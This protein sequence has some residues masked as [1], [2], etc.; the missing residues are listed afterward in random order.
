MS[1]KG[2]FRLELSSRLSIVAMIFCVAAISLVFSGTAVGQDFKRS[3]GSVP[4]PMDWS[5]HHVIYTVGFTHEQASKML[6]DPRFFVATRSHGKALAD[7]M[8]AMKTSSSDAS[9]A[10]PRPAENW[11]GGG[12]NVMPRRTRPTLKKDW[13]ISLGAGGVAQ[14]MFP[15]KYSFDVTAT[16]SCSAD[17]VVFPINAS[18]GNTR[19]HVVGTF[20]AEPATGG[21]TTITVTP[22][23]GTAATLTLTSSASSNSGLYFEVSST[24]AT[25]ATNLA[26]AIN[27][28]LS[29]VALDGV[30]AV[31]SGS[32]VTV[33]TLTPGTRV[34]L[35]DANTLT[36]F[37]W[38][39]VTAGTNG[40]QANIVAMNQLYS[41]TETSGTSLCGLTNPEFIF[42]YASGVGPVA[43]S[44]TLS[45]TGKKVA[46]VENDTNIGAILHILTFGSGSTEYGTSTSC[47][48]NNNGGSTLPTCATSPVIPGSTSGS[49]ATDFMLPLGLVAANASTGVAGAA[50]SFSSPFTNYDDDTTFV[51]DNNGYLYA[52]K[53][54]FIGTPAYAGGNFPVHVSATPTSVTPTA[55]T[56]TTT[57]VTVTATNS[58]GIG[59][60]VT[61][62]GVA[63]NGN[64]CS[65][66]DATAI[67]GTQTVISSSS[68]QFTFDATI[69]RATTGAGCT[70]TNATVTAGSNYLSS[71]VVD[72]AGTGN[73]FVA[74]SSSNLYELTS[75]G[76]TA[77]TAISVGENV[78]GGVRVAPMIDST[79]AVGYVTT[80][81]NANA[82]GETDAANPALVQFKF[83]SNTLTEVG[84]AALDT[85]MNQNC[86]VA[87]YP[88]YDPTPDDRYYALGISSATAASNGEFIAASSGTGGQQIKAFQFVSSALQT[89]PEAKPQIGDGPSPL[90]PLTEFYNSESFTVSAVTATTSVV[91]VTAANAL[92][93]NDLVTISGVTSNS[94]CSAADVAAINGLQTVASAST[95]QF[96]FAATIP[97]ATSGS[98]C[99]ITS[100]TAVG[101][102]D[103]MFMGVVQNTT[104]AYSF[105][106]P[107]G[108]VSGSYAAENT[109]SVTGGTSGIVVDN[110]STSAQASSLYFGTLATSTSQCG[111][112]A[113]YCAVKLTQSLLE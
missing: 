80:A 19:A 110:D 54:T 60:L 109:S 30:A 15:A 79:N 58:L 111:T 46:Y 100:A 1:A 97:T 98:G 52:I 85:A 48:S 78:N 4:L 39:T 73:I 8:L 17:F 89:T 25:N 67:N 83:T 92:A 49:T 113:A 106:L 7:A 70:V 5:N 69:P 36:N 82:V 56:A 101:G 77:A 99:T 76:A 55:V 29:T 63:A 45:L 75:A 91:T 74:D 93:A 90:S 84:V 65:S 32:T 23:G 96:T 3:D 107:S 37:S 57:V 14:G 41:G 72:V 66:A 50:D 87:G 43:T 31:A 16:P 12:W 26:A 103:Y 40:S 47:A 95:T 35:T 68:T 13:S 18:T 28:N 11:A 27:R 112:T 6:G 38:G 9:K 51:G 42:S 10:A 64:S 102:P 61:I 108:A 2:Y 24:V 94:N 44:P 21:T 88:M 53:P 20:T 59:E 71:P 105:L 86:V 22:T 33:Y 34:T 81:C 104:G 62:A